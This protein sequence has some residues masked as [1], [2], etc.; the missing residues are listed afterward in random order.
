MAALVAS[1]VILVS[2]K[3]LS[4]VETFVANNGGHQRGGADEQPLPNRDS[5]SSV[6]CHGYPP[7]WMSW[8]FANSD[9]DTGKIS[10]TH[11]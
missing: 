10:R 2:R 5:E 3:D 6:A 8:N 4:W 1:L 9:D 7:E 11:G